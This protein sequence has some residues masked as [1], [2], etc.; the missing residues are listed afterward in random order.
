MFSERDQNA[1]DEVMDNFNFEKVRQVM[2]FL[3][4]GWGMEPDK[5]VPDVPTLKKT[6]RSL[7]KD[8][9][10]R[11]NN[12]AEQSRQATGGFEVFAYRDP[13]DD[14]NVPVY[15]ELKFVVEDWYS[16]E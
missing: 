15:L 16:G 13:K 12:G 9:T 3:D 10:H 8:A 5:A 2:Q 14:A 4:W 6:A 11:I 7:L 1:I